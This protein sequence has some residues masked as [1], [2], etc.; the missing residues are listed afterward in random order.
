MAFRGALHVALRDAGSEKGELR[1]GDYRISTD[2]YPPRLSQYKACGNGSDAGLATG[3][4]AIVD[5]IT[6][7]LP[8]R[9]GLDFGK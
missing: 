5:Y 9:C 1:P 7:S 8:W 6:N 3:R 2:E 4:E